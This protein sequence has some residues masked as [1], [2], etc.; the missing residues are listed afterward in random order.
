MN[1]TSLYALTVPMTIKSLGNLKVI[2]GKAKAFAEEKKIEEI[3]LLES[4]LALDQYPLVKQVQIACD[5]AKGTAARLANVEP[6]KMEDNEKTIAELETRIDTTI[7]FVQ[8]LTE[9]QFEGSEER[10]I[11]IYFMP[12]KYM[13]GFEYVTEMALPNFFFHLTTAYSILRHHGLNIG[14]TDFIGNLD[15]KDE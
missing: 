14:K 11:P 6:P 3:V 12:G 2:L 9:A 7:T 8:T 1:K 13:L 10:K 5:N 15:L 4:R